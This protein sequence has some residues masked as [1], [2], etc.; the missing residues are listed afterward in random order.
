FEHMPISDIRR[1][2]EV[3]STRPFT[4]VLFNF[5]PHTATT[6]LRLLDSSWADREVE[7]YDRT[8]QAL[9][10]NIFGD[11]A[12][13]LQ[14]AWDGV[15]CRASAGR[16]FVNHL[17]ALLDELA[18]SEP[19]I[20]IGDL[21]AMPATQLR[22]L[23]G[24][25]DDPLPADISL[26]PTLFAE[27]VATHPQRVALVHD[28]DRLSYAE[29]DARVDAIAAMLLDRGVGY[30]ARVGIATRRSADMLAAVL[31]THRV[32]AAYVPL[33]PRYPSERLRFMVADSGVRVVVTDP[34]S[35]SS[36]P[37]GVSEQIVLDGQLPS[38][39][40][41]I[42]PASIR[43]DTLSH[44]IYTSGST[45]TP[46]GV[47]IEHGSVAALAD[48]AR[49]TFSDAE[50]AGV[51]ASTSL[52]FDL[53][54]FELLITLAL[55]GSVVLVDDLFALADTS[56]EGQIVL[57]NSV[58]SLITQ[59]LAVRALP[60]SVRTVTLA[61]EALPRTLVNRL[62]EQPG[63]EAVWNLYGPSE[64]TTY[65]TGVR[66]DRDDGGAPSIGRPL[67]GT[68]VYV[69]SP[70]LRPVPPG[71]CGELLLGGA[72]LARGYLDRPELTAERFIANPFGGPS[73]RLYRTGDRVSWR[74]DGTLDYH[75]RLDDQVK[76]RGFRIEPGE[77]RHALLEDHDIEDAAVLVRPE[78]G[79]RKLVAYV[80]GR[81]ETIDPQTTRQRLAASLPAHLVPASVV[82]LD[83]LPLTPSG[84]L[85]RDALPA[86]RAAAASSGL[87]GATETA[88][89]ALWQEVLELDAPP[90]ADDDF[91]ALGADSFDALA[92]L[93]G[94]E[95]RFGRWLGAAAM[96]ESTTLADMVARLDLERRQQ[97]MSPVISVRENGSRPPWFFAVADH[98]AVIAMRNV[99][100]TLMYDQPVYAVHTI[101]P[102]NPAWRMSS[103]E[104]I[105][106]KCLSAIRE[107][108]P[109]GPYRLGGYSLGGY[110]GWELACRLQD[111]G[112]EVELLVLL[113]T[114]APYAFSWRGQIL[115]RGREGRG[116]PVRRRVR[117]Y[118]GLLRERVQHRLSLLRRPPAPQLYSQDFDER[119]DHPGAIR[120]ARRY[121]PRPFAGPVVVYYTDYSARVSDEPT[122]WW[123]RHASGTLEAEWV[124]GDHHSV[125]AAS[126]VATF[127]G[128]LAERLERLDSE[129]P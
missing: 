8:G 46:K 27:K 52:S 106:E 121:R 19:T 78:Q 114:F 49:D 107:R 34:G 104:A 123:E 40:H 76:L 17:A 50:R 88:M 35:A 70:A 41:A 47:M 13:L 36:L 14:T 15:R 89:G 112:E 31:A 99:L 74:A 116:Y 77:V 33:D 98:R 105:T 42:P 82:V 97:S 101:D 86:P 53:S 24:E 129:R 120:L 22:V 93:A 83:A 51:L 59:L 117:G 54:V 90:G 115:V 128:L 102:A 79:D 44:V 100:P 126:Q 118:G 91:F 61:G 5:Q 1:V 68:Q 10:L 32:G 69:V 7:L 94:I 45:G 58:P 81:S 38:G 110:V 16:R 125:L 20:A 111:M 4:E 113:D 12:I 43:S 25:L 92:L 103:V 71:V 9:T 109:H 57:I 30:E 26:I 124:P 55:G 119:W 95:A 66:C 11:E 28:G 62:F 18:E 75:G 3:P 6:A 127:S 96:F 72:G 63:V 23:S 87:T 56:F 73:E 60:D 39:P 84:K 29:L 80:V 65:S 2:S 37:A 108:Q 48:W 64:D 21:G 122:L 67:P 85:D